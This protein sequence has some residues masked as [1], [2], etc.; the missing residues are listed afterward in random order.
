[1]LKK[2]IKQP[3]NVKADRLL[4]KYSS[5]FGSMRSQ[6]TYQAQKVV[7]GEVL[8]F[9]APYVPFDKGILNKSGILNT[10]LGSGT[11][12]YATP[13]ASKLYYNP[14]YNFQG[15]PIRGAF[16]FERMKVAHKEEIR[17]DAGEKFR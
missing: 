16:W 6:Q 14:G 11:V 7:D 12:K 5:Q 13:Y 8:R 17:K 2:R 3:K 1:M 9:C 15:A 4:L 10:V